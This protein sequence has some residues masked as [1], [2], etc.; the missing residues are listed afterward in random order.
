MSNLA[1]TNYSA[2][3]HKRYN[4]TLVQGNRICFGTIDYSKPLTLENSDVVILISNMIEYSV[5][6]DEYKMSLSKRRK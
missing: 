6:R 3:P 4:N 2:D 1:Y 5:Y